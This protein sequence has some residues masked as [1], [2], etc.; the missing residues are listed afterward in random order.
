MTYEEYLDSIR[1]LIV[2]DQNSGDTDFELMIPRMIEYAELRIHRDLDL[3][4]AHGTAAGTALTAGSRDT[5]VPA[6][7]LIVEGLNVVSPAGTAP[8][9][10]TRISLDRVSLAFLNATWPVAA[11]TGVPAKYALLSDTAVR[12]APTPNGAYQTEFIGM[13]RPTLLSSAQAT[14]FI[15]TQLPDL[16]IAASMVFVAGYQQNYGAAVNNPEM[17]GSWQTQYD[18]LLAGVNGEELRRKAAA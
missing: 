13:T 4:T 14:T 3:L 17:A 16:L 6:S 9:A 18:K 12:I 2:T 11:T 15:S 7:I 5:T 10:G 1:K 8:E